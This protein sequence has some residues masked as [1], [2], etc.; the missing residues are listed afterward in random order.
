LNPM[1][2]HKSA[3]S[4]DL[5]GLGGHLNHWSVVCSV[6]DRSL[7]LFD[8]SGLHRIRIDHRRTPNEK[9]LGTTVEHILRPGRIIHLAMRD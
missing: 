4:P 9:K 8:S 1:P 7:R 5:I 6:G 2:L 3:A